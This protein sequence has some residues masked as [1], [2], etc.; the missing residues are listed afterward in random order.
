M[1]IASWGTYSSTI[2]RLYLASVLAMAP[3][4]LGRGHRARGNGVGAAPLPCE[5]QVQ[6]QV[7]RRVFLR[8]LT[9]LM[10]FCAFKI[11]KAI[12]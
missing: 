9:Y 6:G 1:L 11:H 5:L 10:L 2:A 7:P 4:R 12:F 3:L 8:I